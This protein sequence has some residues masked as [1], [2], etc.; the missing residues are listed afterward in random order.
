MIALGWMNAEFRAVFYL[1]ITQMKKA[2]IILSGLLLLTFPIF[3]QSVDDYIELVRDVLK[4]EKKA[5][6]AEVLQLSDAESGPFWNLYNE[7]DLA[8]NKIHNQRIA[9]IKD[10]AAN[11]DNLSAAKA[12]ELVTKSLSY[13]Q[14]ILKLR[15]SYYPKFKKIVPVGKAATYFQLEN[16]IQ[17][18]VDAQLA[19]EIPM[20]EV[21]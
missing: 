14:E 11:F 9:I 1:T 3:A 15:K 8:Q 6:V 13:Q 2:T 12:D 20:A 19:M 10:F 4:T 21:K 7:F 5:I 17:T 18:M 16:K